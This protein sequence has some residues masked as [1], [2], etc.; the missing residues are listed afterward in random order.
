MASII[1]Y[2]NRNP[3]EITEVVDQTFFRLLESTAPV[4]RFFPVVNYTTREAL[5][6]RMSRKKM[7]MAQL[8]APDQEVQAIRPQVTM[9]EVTQSN[10]KVGTKLYWTES[11]F[12]MMHNL[13]M[14][15]AGGGPGRAIAEQAIKDHF[16][17]TVQELVPSVYEKSLYL[18]M[19]KLA[20]IGQCNYTDPISGYKIAIDAA[21]PTGHIAATLTGGDRWSEAATCNPLAN[22]AAHAEAIYNGT[23]GT[24][25]FPMAV[26]MHRTDLRRIADST[27]AKTAILRKAGADS[28]TPAVT[29]MYLNDDT[30]IELIK[31]RTRASEV[32]VF[33]AQYT[34]EAADG[35]QTNGYFL[36]DDYYQF[37]YVEG[38]IE[39]AFVPT[40][41]RDFAPGLYTLNDF[42]SKLPRREF[43]AVAGNFIPY[44][45]DERLIGSRNVCNTAIS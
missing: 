23:Y 22:L 42:D 19:S 41:E 15:M 34:A 40:V 39:R 25:R 26:I 1:E 27:E 18:V 43:S 10:V 5:V 12:I 38:N 33:D 9:I 44:V 29:G 31:E 4:E 30:V 8:L 6:A 16:F 45:K 2:L 24:G 32:I 35:T 3:R 17:G 20:S 28:T 21:V 36:P 14:Q 7:P 37:V 11:D 13:Q